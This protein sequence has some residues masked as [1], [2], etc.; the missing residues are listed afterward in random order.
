VTIDGRLTEYGHPAQGV[1]QTAADVTQFG[2]IDRYITRKITFGPSPARCSQR[3]E[4][5][6]NE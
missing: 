1:A 4:E 3:E 6:T 5:I 2:A